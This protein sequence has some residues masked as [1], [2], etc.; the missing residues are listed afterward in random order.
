MSSGT[1]WRGVCGQH[2]YNGEIKKQPLGQDPPPQPQRVA[3][4]DPRSILGFGVECSKAWEPGQLGQWG[5]APIAGVFG[6][7]ISSPELRKL[8]TA[9]RR[10]GVGFF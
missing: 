1:G 7:P 10:A 6:V 2:G 9:H 8:G 3:A 4:Q 5:Q